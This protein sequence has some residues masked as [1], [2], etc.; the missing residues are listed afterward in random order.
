MG[1]SHNRIASYLCYRL[2]HDFRP[3]YDL[4]I[5]MLNFRSLRSR[6]LNYAVSNNAIFLPRTEK[7][8]KN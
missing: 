5:S 7:E 3:I 2:T 4:L 8:E 1:L 6:L